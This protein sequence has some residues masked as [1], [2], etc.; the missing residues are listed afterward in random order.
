MNTPSST[1]VDT[2]H[3][4]APR[5]ASSCLSPTPYKDFDGISVVN[6]ITSLVFLSDLS[7]D[8][9]YK[10]NKQVIPDYTVQAHR[11]PKQRELQIPHNRCRTGKGQ[12]SPRFFD[13]RL[14]P[15][16]LRVSKEAYFEGTRLLYSTN[17]FSFHCIGV[18]TRFVSQATV[19]Q[20]THI[21]NLRLSMNFQGD[22]THVVGPS[23]VGHINGAP[24]PGIVAW[25]GVFSDVVV[26]RL[27]D[28]ASLSL[29]IGLEGTWVCTIFLSPP[30]A[31]I[32]ASTVYFHT[33]HE[34]FT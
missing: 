10:G 7:E 29:S 19:N 23:P 14:I 26:P 12:L 11:Y 34:T 31:N 15:N 18:L 4:I 25:W 8:E 28:L 3:C 30:S 13:R 33:T 6:R 5:D 21:Q 24:H 1:T 16:L 32:I 22:G 9:L 2:H 17:T 27:P 20:R